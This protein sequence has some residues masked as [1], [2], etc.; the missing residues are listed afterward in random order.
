MSTAT[1]SKGSNAAQAEN[2]GHDRVLRGSGPEDRSAPFGHALVKA[3]RGRPAN[4]RPHRRPGQVHGHAHLRAGV[5]GAVLP[6]GH[7]RAVALR[8]GRRVGRDRLGAVRVHLLGVRRAPGLRLPLPGHRRAEPEREHRGRPARPDHRLR[9][10][11]PG[12]RGHGDFPRHAQPDHRGSVRLGGHRTGGAA[13]RGQRRPHV[14]APAARQRPHGAGRVRL[15][16]RTRQGEGAARRQRRRVRLQRADD[17]AGAAGRQRRWPHTTWTSPSCT[18][19]PSN[20]ST[21]PPSWPR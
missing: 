14:P 20:R 8:C 19:P 4:R 6:D 5:P 3:A 12:H 2:V 1:A 13:A 7:G 15:H 21:P 17:H 16:L 18:R 10:Q 9:P 11:P